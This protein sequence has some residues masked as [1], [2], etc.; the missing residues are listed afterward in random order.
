MQRLSRVPG[1]E[2]LLIL[3]FSILNAP[4]KTTL[5]CSRSLPTARLIAW[6]CLSFHC[7]LL[8]GLPGAIGGQTTYGS[9]PSP[10]S[11]SIPSSCTMKVWLSTECAKC[12]RS[13][14]VRAWLPATPWHCWRPSVL[15]LRYSRYIQSFCTALSGSTRAAPSQLSRRSASPSCSASSK[16]GSLLTSWR[17]SMRSCSWLGSVIGLVW[18]FVFR[19]VRC[20]GGPSWFVLVR[21]L[22]PD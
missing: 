20:C 10:R 1:R 6:E 18:R 14:I 22:V 15:W 17:R 2:F 13:E 11:S 5:F 3:V 19:H 21:L 8:T 4:C 12:V 16:A 9:G 7:A